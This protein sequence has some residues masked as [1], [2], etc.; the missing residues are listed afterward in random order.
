MLEN[1]M[2]TIELEHF[3]L[4]FEIINLIVTEFEIFA[5]YINLKLAS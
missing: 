5:I 1:I 4:L 2:H 3:V